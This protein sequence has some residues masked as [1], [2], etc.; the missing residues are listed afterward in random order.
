MS[1]ADGTSRA[2]QFT[3][4]QQ[5]KLHDAAD[6]GNTEEA[7][8]LVSEGLAH[9]NQPWINPYGNGELP[10]CGA[11]ANGHTDTVEALVSLN[12]DVHRAES[13]G[14]RHT[15]LTTAAWKGHTATVAKLVELGARPSQRNGEG[16]S[17][18]ELA[19]Q[20]NH[21]QTASVLEQAE[22]AE[23]RQQ[24]ALCAAAQAGR[25]EE[26][27]RLLEEGADPSQPGSAGK[28]PRALAE[29]AGHRQTAAALE[30]AE[31]DAAVTTPAT[32]RHARSLTPV[33]DRLR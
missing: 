10:L 4:Q 13:W 28:Q 31:V 25:T 8:R 5:R 19:L 26:V 6:Y 30:V 29:E 16:K 21:P 12:A 32:A 11:A 14:A 7:V 24:E 20:R 33:A 3:N 17:P 23:R 18:R 15:P 2:P 9:P 27:V 1:D 22:Q